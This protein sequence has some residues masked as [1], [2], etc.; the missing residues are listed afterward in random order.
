MS[1]ESKS[2]ISLDEAEI[3]EALAEETAAL[4]RIEDIVINDDEDDEDVDIND[5]LGEHFLIFLI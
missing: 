2:R 3:D 1:M 5:L 4:A